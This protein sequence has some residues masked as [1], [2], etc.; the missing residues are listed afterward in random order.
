M[1]GAFTCDADRLRFLRADRYAPLAHPGWQKVE[2]ALCHFAGINEVMRGIAIHEV[3]SKK[4]K[5]DIGVQQC[6]CITVLQCIT[7][8]TR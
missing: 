3:V 1:C 4:R 5:N 6:Q 2:V 8:Y 7:V